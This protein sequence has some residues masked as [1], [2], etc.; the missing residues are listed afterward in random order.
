MTQRCV[1][2][3]EAKQQ[4]KHKILVGKICLWGTP[5]TALW[6]LSWSLSQYRVLHNQEN[7]EYPW[8]ISAGAIGKLEETGH[9]KAQKMLKEPQRWSC[10]LTK[11]AL[12]KNVPIPDLNLSWALKLAWVGCCPTLPSGRDS[13]MLWIHVGWFISLSEQNCWNKKCS[14]GIRDADHIGIPSSATE[15]IVPYSRSSHNTV[16]VSFLSPVGWFLWGLA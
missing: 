4:N 2:E 14:A 8:L 9:R 1:V 6:V 11:I 13:V 10:H 12:R 3:W 7:G 15:G 5:K 16:W